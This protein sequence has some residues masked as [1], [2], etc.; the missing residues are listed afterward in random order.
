MDVIVCTAG[1]GNFLRTSVCVWI[2]PFW[3]RKCY[4]L[5]WNMSWWSHSAQ[6]CSRNIE[7][8]KI[9]IFLILSFCP[10]CYSET[11]ITSFN[12]AMQD[13][14]WLVFVKTFGTR[15]RSV[16][17]HGR[18]YHRICHQLNLYVVNSVADVFASP[19]QPETLQ[20]LRDALVHEWNHWLVLCVRDAKLSLLQEVVTH[21]TEL[22][23]PP[24]CMTISVCPW[25][26]LIMILRN[27]A[28][29][30]LFVMPIWI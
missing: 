16:F 8:R 13:V 25:F 29:I 27:V 14:T 2:R 6:N 18:H 28:D 17:L 30:A 19:N 21:V 12:M 22:C 11:S 1:V 20:D 3:S 7:C 23:K 26:V 15:I 10:F 5:C 9:H 4:G 24:Y